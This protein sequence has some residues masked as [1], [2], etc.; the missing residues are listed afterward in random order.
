LT[1]NDA[2][3]AIESMS[4]LNKEAGELMQHHQV[5][6][7]TDITGFGL[8]GHLLGMVKASNIK[9]VIHADNVPFFEGVLELATGGILPGGTKNNFEYT[10]PFVHYAENIPAVRQMMLN[11]AQTSGGLLVSLP[12]GEAQK[13]IKALN[14]WGVPCAVS[15]GEL[16]A[17]T[18]RKLK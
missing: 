5:H 11:D 1:G 12:A 4:S 15:I 6:A 10:R 18:N 3:A 14:T 16:V 7:C 8:L 17:S 9:A 2:K 13:F